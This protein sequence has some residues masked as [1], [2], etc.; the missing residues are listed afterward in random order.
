MK[1]KD[2]ISR[3]YFLANNDLLQILGNSKN[4]NNIQNHI[5]KMLIGANKLI[6]HK[7]IEDDLYYI[8]GIQSNDGEQVKF[9]SSIAMHGVSRILVTKDRK[10]YH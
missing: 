4:P 9:S 10:I 6:V 3:F 1:P 5:N 7:D 2:N 8:D